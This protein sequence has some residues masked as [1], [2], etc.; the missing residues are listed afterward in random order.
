MPLNAEQ[1]Q[2]MAA[3]AQEVGD[4]DAELEALEGLASIG[5]LQDPSFTDQAI[6]VAETGLAIG[7]AALGE[8]VGGAAG[9]L[10][11]VATGDPQAGEAVLQSTQQALTYNPRTE[12]GQANLQA[13]ADNET[14]QTIGDT[15]ASVEQTLGDAGFDV[16]GPIGGAIAQ[17][18]PTAILEGLGLVGVRR[19]AKTGK[20]VTRGIEAA[21]EATGKA[22]FPAAKE[23]ADT[24]TDLFNFQSPAKQKI[25]TIL[26]ESPRAPDAAGFNL[27]EG[28]A[29]QSKL[30]KAIGIGGPKVVKDRIAQAAIK[31]GWDK[32]VIATI[33]GASNPDKAA[34]GRMM[35][36][37]ENIKRD[38]LFGMRNR[39][40]DVTGDLLMSRLKVVR[41]ANRKAGRAIDKASTSLKGKAV[42]VSEI[43]DSFISDLESMG[44]TVG[45]DT[46]KLIPDFKGS[47]IEF[48][49]GPKSTIRNILSRM[50]DSSGKGFD[51]KSVHDMKRL[52]DTEVT[53]GKS[54]KGLT[55][56][57]ERA[58]KQFRANLNESIRD[59]SPDYK[60]ANTAYADT[61]GALD[62]FQRVAG[63]RMNL[64]G[65]NADKATGTL[66]RRLMGNAQ[67]RITLLDAIDQIEDVA[68]RHGGDVGQLKIGGKVAKGLDSD[69]LTQ[70]L[71]ADEL[72]S[73][74]GPAART[75][76]QGQFDQTMKRA[77]RAS[78]T[79]GGAADAALDVAGE[80]LEKARGINEEAAIKAMKDLIRG[81]K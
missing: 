59:I 57:P 80:A 28:G 43:G 6:G 19:A 29:P 21:G 3:L 34:F 53:Y 41:D 77:A 66:M 76:L 58:L 8:A 71:F 25:A 7:G 64:T 20:A 30:G 65:P 15:L 38:A 1:Y 33:K 22:V 11:T 23:V 32:G 62:E 79:K 81:R 31:Q 40:S 44:I 26:Q 63:N 48:A 50:S 42:D 68:R 54:V 17:A 60:A 12:E 5:A 49:G 72:D 56:G 37:A 70:V 2:E 27:L 14:I 52:I 36:V 61:I 45:R 35:Q 74:L 47:D 24:A 16:A 67:S 9:L 10:T 39:P 13:I 75:S 73:I 55:G 18:I 78:T 69:L 4:E 46:G 51:A